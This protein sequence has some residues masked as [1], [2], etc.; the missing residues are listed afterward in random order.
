MRRIALAET[1][2]MLA[3]GTQ[4]LIVSDGDVEVITHVHL[5]HSHENITYPQVDHIAKTA[6]CIK[7]TAVR[8]KQKLNCSQRILSW[9][10][11][12]TPQSW[13]TLPDF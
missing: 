1:R 12:G 10:K 9:T 6:I 5:K 4:P 2:A 11:L 13:A 3:H 7:Q 8:K